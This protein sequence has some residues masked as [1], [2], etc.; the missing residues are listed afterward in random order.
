MSSEAFGGQGGV[1]SNTDDLDADDLAQV[2]YLTAAA[3]AAQ[4]FPCGRR[5][6]QQVP[7]AR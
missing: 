6:R 7:M 4:A 1:V 3:R 2:L 5:L